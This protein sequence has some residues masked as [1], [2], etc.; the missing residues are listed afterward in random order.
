MGW[1]PIGAKGMFSG[2]KGAGFLK[3]IGPALFGQAGSRVGQPFIPYKEGILTKLGLTG[4]G[5]SM[6][7]TALG[8]GTA[9][10]AGTMGATA[11]EE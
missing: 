7:P 5:G 6:M 3:G 10:L 8:W 11:F 9:A 1:G 2:A 4:G